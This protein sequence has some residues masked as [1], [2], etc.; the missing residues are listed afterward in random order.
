MTS[1][2]AYESPLQ[3]VSKK[4]HMSVGEQRL[5]NLFVEVHPSISLV[6]VPIHTR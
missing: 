6:L 3:S 4:L 5:T 1:D 2:L